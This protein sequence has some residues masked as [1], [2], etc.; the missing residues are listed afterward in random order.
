MNL[1]PNEDQKLLFD[2]VDSLSNRYYTPNFRADTVTG[3]LGWS[4]EVWSALAELGLTGLTI[5]EEYGGVGAGPAEVYVTLEAL[6]KHGAVEPLLD[7][8]YVPSWLIAA[9]GTAEQQAALLPRL[10]GGEEIFAV[11]H[12]EP[13]RV[14]DAASTVTATPAADGSLLLDGV[15]SPVPHADQA[16]MLLVSAVDRDGVPGVYLVER[17]A[18]GVTRV[19]GRA[20]DWTHASDVTFESVPAT[21][22]GAVGAAAENALAQTFSRARI[23]VAGEAVGL[24]EA[25]LRD[26]VDYLGQ[27]KQ[28]R[29]PLSRFQALVFRAADLYAE[30]ELGR[31]F[32]LWATAVTEDRGADPVVADD[33]FLFIADMARTTAEEAVQLH[34]GIGMTFESPVAHY[35]ARLTAITQSYGGVAAARR[36]ALRAPDLTTVPGALLN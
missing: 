6:G 13:G 23:A 33:A 20:T 22:L 10:A 28:F 35:A 2:T 9:L 32:A 30:V 18:A 24:A 1:E 3:E 27:R 4:A 29:V 12:A 25:A 26:T 8:V 34:G 21:L 7:G 5:D 11:A 19:D 16:T 15:K 17:D 36:R 14:W 31:S